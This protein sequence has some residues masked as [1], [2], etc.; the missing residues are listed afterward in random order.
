MS[1]TRQKPSILGKKACPF[2]FLAGRDFINGKNNT[3]K[4][5]KAFLL[6]LNIYK[7]H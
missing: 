4:W 2:F 7:T 1:S 3:A 6:H 5:S